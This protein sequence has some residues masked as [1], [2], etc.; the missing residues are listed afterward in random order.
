[1]RVTECRQDRF[2]KSE[3]ATPEVQGLTLP[4]SQCPLD[5]RRDA[6]TDLLA[7]A[8]SFDETGVTQNAEMMRNMRLRTA[9][10]LHELGDTSL[11]YEQVLQ[12][13][14]ASFVGQG[15]QDRGALAGRQDLSGRSQLHPQQLSFGE[16][17]TASPLTARPARLITAK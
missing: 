6:I 10:F 12:N 11:S 4:V 17:V 5:G 9:E 1:M 7:L 8:E 15:F 3:L 14:Q 16:Q 2:R 13:A